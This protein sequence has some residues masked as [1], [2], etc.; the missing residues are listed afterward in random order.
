MAQ[1]FGKLEKTLVVV[2]PPIKTRNNGARWSSGGES[3]LSIRSSVSSDSVVA[4]VCECGGKGALRALCEGS[5]TSSDDIF[6]SKLG[7]IGISKL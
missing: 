6:T 5:C 1:A 2:L 3:Y 7:N 4:G